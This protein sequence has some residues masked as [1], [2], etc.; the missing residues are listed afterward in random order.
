MFEVDLPKNSDASSTFFMLIAPLNV[1][2]LLLDKKNF[3]ATTTHFEFDV[4]S[5][6]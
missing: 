6:R 5:I 1:E 4:F 3:Q 2:V